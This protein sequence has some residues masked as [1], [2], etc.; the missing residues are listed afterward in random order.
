MNLLTI[1]MLEAKIESL[2]LDNDSLT[3]R[4]VHAIAAAEKHHEGNR[5]AC[6]REDKAIAGIFATMPMPPDDMGG[7]DGLLAYAEAT[8]Q[9]RAD[10]GFPAEYDGPVGPGA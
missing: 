3:R 9:W 8:L 1:A 4:L 6:E 5:A 7:L 10:C 2:K